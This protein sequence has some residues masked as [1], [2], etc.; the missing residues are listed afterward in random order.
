MSVTMEKIDARR[1]KNKEKRKG[2]AEK[3]AKEKKEKA[4]GGSCDRAGYSVCAWSS[5]LW[6]VQTG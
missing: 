2:T 6:Y 1:E 4:C 3:E 5:S